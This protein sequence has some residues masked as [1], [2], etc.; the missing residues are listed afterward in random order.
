M[1][2]L[3]QSLLQVTEC[4]LVSHQAC[5]KILELALNIRFQYVQT[6]TPLFAF[7]TIFRTYNPSSVLAI[8]LCCTSL[9]PPNIVYALDSQYSENNEPT[10]ASIQQ[11]SA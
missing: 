6:A 2:P 8:I 4:I 11:P 3:R 1:L 9:V 10:D 5:D 7:I